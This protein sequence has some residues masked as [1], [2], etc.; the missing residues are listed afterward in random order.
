[1]R[2]SPCPFVVLAAPVVAALASCGGAP[3]AS[4]DAAERTFVVPFTPYFGPDAVQCGTSYEGAGT[5]GGDFELKDFL[6]FVHSV[7]LIRDDG[8]RVPLTLRDD[9]HWQGQGVA[10]LDFNDASG[11]CQGDAETNAQIVGDA[12]DYDD[13]TGIE[14]GVGLPPELNHLDA[15]TAPA[16][17][18]KPSTWW[19]WQGG[20]KFF[21]MTLK[22]QMHDAFYVHLGAT[23]C[24]GSTDDG[25]SCAAG[26]AIDIAVEDFTPGAD[27]VRLNV[28]TLLAGVDI[29][30]PVDFAAGD[31]I[32]GCMSFDPDP[33]CDGLFTK[34][35]RHFMN[36]EPSDA[37][38]VF[39]C[40]DDAA[41]R[42][43]S[44]AALD[45][46]PQPG[47]PDFVR[48]PALDVSVLSDPTVARSHPAGDIYAIG[49]RSYDRG[50]GAQCVACHQDLG[51]GLGQFALAGTV[52]NPDW[53]TG[54]GGATIKLL[55]IFAGPCLDFD[56]RPHCEGQAPGYFLE[57][58]VVA[59]V[60][61][62]P[63]GNFY[64]TELPPEA[65]PPFWPVVVPG[66]DA[67]GLEPKFMGHPAAS[68]SCNMCHSSF[69]VQLAVGDE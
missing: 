46:S 16:P 12:P 40:D 35:G 54:Y 7:H 39:E 68:G 36:D 19:S 42:S 2:N 38:I 21:Q 33:E 18:N 59:S 52:W 55:P 17:F 5:T 65:V 28:A 60:Q 6:V 23:G 15:V 69:R 43:D 48:D 62:D 24:D 32:A 44:P 49:D 4:A 11:Q 50:A 37:Q 64:A 30:A 29:N 25:F 66:D 3:P 56:E 57:D 41:R 45:D 20:Y 67:D 9:Q 47:S 31:F 26:H 61:T 53:A 27:G 14:F 63:N 13:Y 8:E 1:M 10:L 22:T 34:F 51:P 58:D